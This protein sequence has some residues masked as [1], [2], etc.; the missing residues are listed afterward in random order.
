MQNSIFTEIDAGG[1]VYS[2][3]GTRNGIDL[4]RDYQSLTI[5]KRKYNFTNYG[6]FDEQTAYD[7]TGLGAR[8]RFSL[9]MPTG[10]KEVQYGEESS[11][12]SAPRFSVN[13]L[14]P[15]GMG[16]RWHVKENGLFSD[17]GGTK[18]ERIISTIG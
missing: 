3:A 4:N 7:A 18:A 12:V 14:T 5:Y 1:I 8:N 10:K 2:P 17:G 9:F 11:T 13:Y 15:F 16:N 6:L